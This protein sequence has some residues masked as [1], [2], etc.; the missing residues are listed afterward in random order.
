MEKYF[1]YALKLVLI[2]DSSIGKTAAAKRYAENVFVR[3]VVSTGVDFKVKMVRFEEKIVKLQIWDT[4]GQERYRCITSHY[5]RGTAGVMVFYDVTSRSS[6]VHVQYWMEFI[7]T[8]CAPENVKV[9]LVGCKCDLEHRR[10]VQREEG[11]ALARDLGVP[12]FEISNKTSYNV[13]ECFDAMVKEMLT[14]IAEGGHDP[15]VI[16]RSKLIRKLKEP[17]LTARSS[18]TCCRS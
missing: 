5:F 4:A 12:F 15:D 14:T 8:S 10:T 3:T 9:M 1:D 6:F 7:K 13:S 16:A 17:D 2:G 11:E 18:T